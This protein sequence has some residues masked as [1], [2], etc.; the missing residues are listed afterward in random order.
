MNRRESHIQW[1][2]FA[3][4]WKYWP[5]VPSNMLIPSMELLEAWLWTMS[6]S[7][8]RPRRWASSMRA[9]SSSGVPE[10]LLTPKKLVTWYPNDP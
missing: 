1:Y 2:P 6:M 8:Y 10:R 7:T 9:L 5:S 3:P 4:L